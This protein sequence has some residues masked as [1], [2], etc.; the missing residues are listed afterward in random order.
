MLVRLLSTIEDIR[1]T[2]KLHSAQLQSIMKQLQ[3]PSRNPQATM[4]E[5]IKFPL[6]TYEEVDGLEQHL[7]DS[8]TKETLVRPVK[9]CC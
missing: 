9:F 1:Q 7:Q 3:A 8:G 6:A 2:Q 4:P 5:N